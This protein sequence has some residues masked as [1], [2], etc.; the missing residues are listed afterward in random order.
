MASAF[1]TNSEDAFT[2]TVEFQHEPNVKAEKIE[3]YFEIDKCVK[4]LKNGSFIRVRMSFV[5]IG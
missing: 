2:K 5:N 3:D 1:S 4:F